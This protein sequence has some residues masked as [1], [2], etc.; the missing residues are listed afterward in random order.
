MERR[1]EKDKGERGGGKGGRR[2]QLSNRCDG[3]GFRRKN[4]KELSAVV[5]H[6]RN[7]QRKMLSFIIVHSLVIHILHYSVYEKK[8]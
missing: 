4:G 2:V 1:R 5:I 7:S 8:K 6:N 3:R